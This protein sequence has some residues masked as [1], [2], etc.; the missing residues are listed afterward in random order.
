VIAPTTAHTIARLAVG[1]ADDVLTTT[2]LATTAPVI[3]APAMESHMYENAATQENLA[4]LKARG[5]IQ[6]G[7]G[8]GHLASGGM[9]WGRLVETEEL[10]AAISQA[11]GRKGDL[12]GVKMVV[13]AGGTQEPLDRCATSPTPPR[14]RWATLWP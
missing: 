2:V 12:A 1:L 7:P 4:R 9:G 13:S 14:A 10:L 5:F 11:L 3:L 8:R 6:V